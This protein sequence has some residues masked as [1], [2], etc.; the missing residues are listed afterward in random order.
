MKAV[1]TALC[2]VSVLI[3]TGGATGVPRQPRTMVLPRFDDGLSLMTYNV[4]GL[5]WP[6]VSGRSADLTAI[7]LRLRD[8]RTRGQAPHVVVLQEAFTRDA[9]AIGKAAGYRYIVDGPSADQTTPAPRAS[10][11]SGFAKAAR[12]WSGE[13]EGKFLGS[14]LQLL[15]DYPILAVRRMAFPTTD[16]AGYDCLANKGAM[17]VRVAVPGMATPVDIVT[18]HLNSRTASGVDK[19]RSD[20][21]Y[22][23]Q[24]D[25]LTR[26]VAGARDIRNPLIVA[27]D[28]NVGKTAA[29]RETLLRDIGMRWSGAGEVRDALG[30]ATHS[31]LP[32]PKDAGA[33]LKRGKDWQFY[34][35]GHAARLE[36]TGIAVPF[37]KEPDGDMLSDHVG[38][39]AYFREVRS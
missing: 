37:G 23:R 18:T 32:V 4:E 36:V 35:A 7:G 2:A 30:Q 16:C 19:A 29:R 14:G 15:S 27:G 38:Y 22:A 24:V 26:F 34:A 3:T 39:V 31:G 17:L 20:E 1:W 9:Q 11:G 6:I 13:T 8:L 5:P 21:A 10:D 33:S 12:W 28:F 25:L